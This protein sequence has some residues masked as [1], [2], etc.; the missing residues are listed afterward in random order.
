[1]DDAAYGAQRLLYKGNTNPLI[2]DGA[3]FCG[4]SADSPPHETG[5][6]VSLLSTGRTG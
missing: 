6:G 3:P 1:M 4:S 2:Q 5:S